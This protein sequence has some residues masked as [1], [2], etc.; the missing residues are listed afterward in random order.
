VVILGGLGRLLGTIVA[1]V[2]VGTLESV[3]T[4]FFGNSFPDLVQFPVWIVEV[5]QPMA[6]VAVLLLVI[7]FIMVRPAG[8]L[9]LKERVYD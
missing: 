7:G 5:N 3:L 6:R 1:G 8:L 9:A 4:K 2:V